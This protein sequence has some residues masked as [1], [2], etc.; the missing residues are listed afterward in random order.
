MTFQDEIR[1][2]A[3]AASQSE[4]DCE[5]VDP[6]QDDPFVV[7]MWHADARHVAYWS[8][9]RA[10]VLADALDVLAACRSRGHGQ[11]CAVF[12]VGKAMP[13]PCNCG[14]TELDARTDTLLAKLEAL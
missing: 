7:S 3:E 8:P 13:W 4:W 10:L 2:R 6:E 14:K 5:P 12:C 1:Q 9:A 11:G